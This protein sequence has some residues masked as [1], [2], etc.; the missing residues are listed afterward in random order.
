MRRDM[1][2]EFAIRFMQS[3]SNIHCDFLAVVSIC[4]EFREKPYNCRPS[5]GL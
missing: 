2:H 1:Q 3:I 4:S 5:V